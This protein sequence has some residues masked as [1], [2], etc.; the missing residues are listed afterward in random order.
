M[1]LLVQQ[2]A[3]VRATALAFSIP[4]L[5][6]RTSINNG[7]L[8]RYGTGQGRQSLLI[9]EDVRAWLR[10]HPKSSKENRHVSSPND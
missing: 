5:H 3:S 8:Q 7:D 6:L 2:A 10:R 1:K 9:F 4:V